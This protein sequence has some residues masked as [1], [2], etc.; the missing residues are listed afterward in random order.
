MI[1]VQALVQSSMS[2]QVVALSS[3]AQSSC[4]V[5]QNQIVLEVVLVGGMERVAM[6]RIGPVRMVSA[7][8]QAA[9]LVGASPN[10]MVAIALVSGSAIQFIH[11][12]MQPGWPAVDEIIQVSDQP[13]EPS[14][15]RVTPTGESGQ[16]VG[17]YCQ[18]VPTTASPAAK[19]AICSAAVPQ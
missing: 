2:L 13:V 17:L 7:A 1:S 11:R 9:S 14:A 16:V 10:Q 8:S 3:S 5:V 4:G 12:Y 18:L 15:G 6:P 19:D